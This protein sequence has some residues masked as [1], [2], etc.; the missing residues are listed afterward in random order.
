MRPSEFHGQ[1]GR[2]RSKEKKREEERLRGRQ[3]EREREREREGES[4]R[5]GERD[6]DA[7]REEETTGVG[8]PSP[9]PNR[10]SR[11]PSTHTT[12]HANAMIYALV[13]T[14]P[15]ASSLFTDVKRLS[16]C[17]NIRYAM[18]KRG[19]DLT[20][21]SEPSYVFSDDIKSDS[22]G[23]LEYT[24]SSEPRTSGIGGDLPSRGEEDKAVWA[25]KFVRTDVRVGGFSQLISQSRIT[26]GSAASCPGRS[27]PFGGY[28][29]RDLAAWAGGEKEAVATAGKGAPPGLMATTFNAVCM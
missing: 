28:A 20:P 1:K 13:S 10:N 23:A 14:L 4:G 11:G 22:R 25:K 15:G 17:R 8:A 18:L 6:G 3:A 26:R 12:G 9:P 24:I 16:L 5:K 2:E 7:E 21:T 19:I 27:G 29:G